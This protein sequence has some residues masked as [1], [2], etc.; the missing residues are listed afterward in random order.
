MLVVD[1]TYE[2]TNGMTILHLT[3]WTCYH[4]DV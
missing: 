3:Y 1:C 4:M 2:F